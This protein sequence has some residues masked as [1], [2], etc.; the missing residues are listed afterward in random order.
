MIFSLENNTSKFAFYSTAYSYIGK[1]ISS[2]CIALAFI[3]IVRSLSVGDYGR[4]TLYLNA[5]FFVTLLLDLGVAEV[6]LRYIPEF[7]ER[8]EISLIKGL[9]KRSI[10]IISVTGI[11]VISLVFLM[12]LFSPSLISRFQL[13]GILPYIVIFGWLRIITQVFGNILN[14]FFFQMYRITCEIFIYVLR[15]VLIYILLRY[16]FGAWALI[17]LYGFIDLVIIIIFYT[18][19]RQPLKAVS[20]KNDKAGFLRMQ[21]FGINEYLYKLFWFFTDNRFDIYLVGFILGISSAGYFAFAAGIVNLLIDWSPGLIVR[22][23]VAPL[24]IRAY[25]A[26]KDIF[27]IQYLFQL[28]NKFLI[29]FTLPVL[30]F[31][32]IL[33]NQIIIYI[34]DPKYLPS[35]NVLLIFIISMFFINIIIP[36]RNILAIMERTDI[37]SISN[38]VAIPNLVLVFFLAKLAG[39][40]GVAIAYAISLFLIVWINLVL[41]KKVIELNYPWKAFSKVAINSLI[42]S[43]F[44]FL[45]KAKIHSKESL[46]F[47]VIV[48]FLIYFIVAYLNKAFDQVDREIFNRAFKIKIWNF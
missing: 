19:I 3:I 33:I 42:A 30:L 9:L 44:I 43:I 36:L 34:F 10:F 21:R 20:L 29:F 7:V 27:Q 41:I 39:I 45:L 31:L 26:N 11:I 1:V 15:L 8:G 37:S 47:V 4:Y 14:A 17:V 6:M 28:H 25:T 5:V 35:S 38:I 16:G 40:E 23:I 48:G 22:P 32:A 18:K 24:F 2:L 13:V 46:I 12:I